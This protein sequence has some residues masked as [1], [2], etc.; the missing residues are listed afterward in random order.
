MS[1]VPPVGAPTAANGQGERGRVAQWLRRPKTVFGLL[2]A[3][4]AIWFILANNTETRIH[5]WVVWVSTKLWVGL[6]CTFVAGLLIGYLLKRRS[7]AK[8]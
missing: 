8:E 3:I 2:I 6:L 5:F 1:N 4:L 7:R